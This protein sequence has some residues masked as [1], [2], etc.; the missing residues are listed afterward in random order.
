[1]EKGFVYIARL[2]DYKNKFVGNYFKVGK[3]QQ[4]QYKIRETQ[5]NSTHLPFDVIF[6]RVFETDFMSSL[7]N[8]LHS[9]FTDYRC[10]KNYPNKKSIITEWF[11]E[12]DE[13]EFHFR[14]DKVVKDF[15]NT[16]E[17]NIVNEINRDNQTSSIEKQELL[18]AISPSNR[19]KLEIFWNNE[20]ITE[21]FAYL[22]FINA[23]IKI[24]EVVG[25]ERLKDD[26]WYFSDNEQ[27]YIDSFPKSYNTSFTRHLGDYTIFVAINNT[28]KARVINE[29]ISKY[30]L[31]QMKVILSDEKK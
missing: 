10:A 8:I 21:K 14:I 24:S 22:T 6:V 1:M 3:T 26:C 5:L 23:L 31:S 12:L 15:P 2:I 29:L 18:E 9:C 16:R 13:E 17:I 20:D 25:P 4:Q 11:D 30:D 7:E 27:K 28:N 19:K